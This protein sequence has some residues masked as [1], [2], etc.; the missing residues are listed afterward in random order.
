M[1]IS[2]VYLSADRILLYPIRLLIGYWILATAWI[3]IWAFFLPLPFERVQMPVI[4]D[5]FVSLKSVYETTP[6]RVPTA[7]AF[8]RHLLSGQ[9]GEPAP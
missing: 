1:Q 2:P 6:D 9:C 5:I 8:F 7:Y 3:S 4:S